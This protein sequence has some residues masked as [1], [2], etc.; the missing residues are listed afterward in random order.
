MR[1][2][3][4]V[5]AMKVKW[6]AASVFVSYGNASTAVEAWL[7]ATWMVTVVNIYAGHQLL[8]QLHRSLVYD[9]LVTRGIQM[10]Q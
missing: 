4:A 8:K 6:T 1:T 3:L 9:H 10:T 5:E 7:V 2:F